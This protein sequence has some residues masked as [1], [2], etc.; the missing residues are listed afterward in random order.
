VSK[1]DTNAFGDSLMCLTNIHPEGTITT[2][3]HEPVELLYLDPD[4]RAYF[5][6]AAAVNKALRGLIALIPD[7][8]SALKN[9]S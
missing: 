1:A 7:D 6:N 3:A 5:L 9:R 4:V 8:T 2:T